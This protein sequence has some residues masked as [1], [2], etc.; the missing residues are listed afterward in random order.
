MDWISYF[1]GVATPLIIYAIYL[2]NKWFSPLPLL[3]K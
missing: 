3:G 2:L 1:L